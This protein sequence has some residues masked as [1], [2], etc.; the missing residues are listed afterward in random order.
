MVLRTQ[1]RRS[2]GETDEHAWEDMRQ[3][4]LHRQQ[5]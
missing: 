4:V 1:Q 2:E 3:T 5:Q